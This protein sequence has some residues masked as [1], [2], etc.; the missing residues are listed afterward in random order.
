MADIGITKISFL[1]SF[2]SNDSGWGFQRPA[3]N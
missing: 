1:Q 2:Y 3:E